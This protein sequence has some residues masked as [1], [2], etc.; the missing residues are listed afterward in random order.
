M[1]AQSKQVVVTMKTQ[2]KTLKS[3]A[4]FRNKSQ[5]SIPPMPMS[6]DSSLQVLWKDAY[7]LAAMDLGKQLDALRKDQLEKQALL[8]QLQA[9]LKTSNDRLTKLRSAFTQLKERYIKLADRHRKLRSRYKEHVSS[10]KKLVNH[11]NQL[12]NSLKKLVK[13]SSLSAS[14]KPTVAKLINKQTDTISRK[15][16]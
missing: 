1:S 5:D 12:R 13:S 11:H 10:Y 3:A 16:P 9:E 2:D 15:K 7:K 6:L 4:P 8:T 14:L